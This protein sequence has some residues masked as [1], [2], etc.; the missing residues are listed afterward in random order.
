MEPGIFGRH[1]AIWV[2]PGPGVN[3]SAGHLWPADEAY[4]E[5][6]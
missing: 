6:S 1:S 5:T 3:F 2:R 4:A